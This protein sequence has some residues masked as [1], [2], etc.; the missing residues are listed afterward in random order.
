MTEQH[1]PDLTRRIERLERQ[2]RNLAR[3][4]I[5]ALALAAVAG[6]TAAAA[7]CKTV[8][9]ERFVLKDPDMRERAVISAYENGGAPRFTLLDHQGQPALTLG[10]DEEGAPYVE[11]RGEDGLVRSPFRLTPEGHPRVAPEDREGLLR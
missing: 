11:V 10:V 5:G 9:A 8:W 6:L 7:V 4:G 3:A 1:R 2:N